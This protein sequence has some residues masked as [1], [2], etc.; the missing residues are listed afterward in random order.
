[1]KFLFLALSLY[2]NLSFISSLLIETGRKERYCFHKMVD[3]DDKIH[4]SFVISGDNEEKVTA[5]L[6]DE[7][8]NI[9]YEQHNADSGDFKGGIKKSGIVKLCFLPQQT[10]N[11]YVSFEFFT[12]FEKG[13]TLNMAKDEN[14]HEMK[15]DMGDITLMFEEM[16]TNVK[17]IM[18]R[19]NRH[20][21]IVSDITS[22]IKQIS[23]L[24]ILVVILVSLLQVFLIHRFFGGA[25]RSSVS[26]GGSV[27]EMSGSSL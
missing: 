27:F 13:H 4:V 10:H 14:L 12:E 18:D 3:Q 9:V 21:Q 5:V 24:K 16:E 20:T 15:K 11:Y 26:Y 1:M 7:Q 2:I 25:K 22:S 19:R 23:Y 17:F 6:T 8:N